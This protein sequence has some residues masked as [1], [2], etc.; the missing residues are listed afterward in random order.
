MDCQLGLPSW[1][2]NLDPKRGFGKPKDCWVLKCF[3]CISPQISKYSDPL[4][5]FA[6]TSPPNAPLESLE[7]FNSNSLN[8][9]RRKSPPVEMPYP[10]RHTVCMPFSVW[11]YGPYIIIWSS[12]AHR[13]TFSRFL[14]PDALLTFFVTPLS[15]N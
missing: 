10:Y 5:V 6:G 2:L 13:R 8:Q 7:S 15:A 3:L 12:F 4:G 9:I 11:V 1:T 14:V